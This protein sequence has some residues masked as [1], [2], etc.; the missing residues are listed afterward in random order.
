MI[1]DF[2]KK[3]II[4]KG[5][6]NKLFLKRNFG[7]GGN[8]TNVHYVDLG[9]YIIYLYG[10][11]HIC[12]RRDMQEISEKIVRDFVRNKPVNRLFL[13]YVFSNKI[14]VKYRSYEFLGLYRFEFNELG[15][16]KKENFNRIL[17]PFYYPSYE[18]GKGYIPYLQYDFIRNNDLNDLNDLNSIRED[19]YNTS[20]YIIDNMKLL[21]M[22]KLKNNTNLKEEFT[23]L[24]NN[25]D[26]LEV[27]LYKTSFEYE[28]IENKQTI[29]NESRKITDAFIGI[30]NDGE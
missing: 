17:T 4:N 6:T 25:L 26:V 2:F 19:D 11:D 22:E 20:N 3:I 1:D 16:L 29:L 13:I 24:I 30:M 5:I 28:N 8:K 12:E 18:E 27:L 9:E 21:L 7:Y 14:D 23:S 10:Y 15:Y